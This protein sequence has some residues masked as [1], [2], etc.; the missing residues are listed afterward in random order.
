MAGASSDQ[1]FD[2]TYAIGV[3][4]AQAMALGK[5]CRADLRQ[6]DTL[7]CASDDFGLNSVFDSAQTLAQCR[8]AH[9][10]SFRGAPEMPMFCDGGKVL[11]VPQLR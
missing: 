5:D 11:D 6:F 1:V 7:R 3:G 9:A 8:L 10:Q 2:L 4:Q